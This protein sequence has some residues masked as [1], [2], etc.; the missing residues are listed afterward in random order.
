M[1]SGTRALH[2]AARNGHEAC[3][4]ALLAG[5]CEAGAADG[6][7]TRTAAA[8]VCA[9]A[10]IRAGAKP[11]RRNTNRHHGDANRHRTGGLGRTLGP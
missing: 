2:Y 9:R 11:R 4:A 3:V 10:A 5:G 8:G 7:R 1:Q 6:V